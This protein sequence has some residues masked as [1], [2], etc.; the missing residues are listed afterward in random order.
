MSTSRFGDRMPN[1][2]VIE[3]YHVHALCRS[4]VK[5]QFAVCFIEELSLYDMGVHRFFLY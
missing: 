3:A 5:Q 2:V 1:F 4:F